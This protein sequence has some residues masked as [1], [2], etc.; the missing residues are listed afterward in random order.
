VLPSDNGDST[1]KAL[2]PKLCGLVAQWWAGRP[3]IRGSAVRSPAQLAHVDVS[4]GKT[5]NPTWLLQL[6]YGVW[7]LV[8]ASVCEWVTD[9]YTCAIHLPLSRS[10]KMLTSCF[11]SG[12]GGL[13]HADRGVLSS[14]NYPQNYLPGLDCSWHVMVT[15]GYRVSVAFQSPFQIQG[16][17]TGCRTGDYL[18][19]NNK[20]IANTVYCVK[21]LKTT[22]I[23]L[24]VSL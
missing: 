15:P 10:F 3:S 9:D 19:V 6:F 17:E 5:L 18:E 8:T 11:R 16:Y 1:L 12:C 22:S 24:Q 2:Q 21:V 7:M 23:R 14:P 20:K 4:L 13:L